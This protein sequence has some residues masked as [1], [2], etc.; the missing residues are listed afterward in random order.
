MPQIAGNGGKYLIFFWGFS[1]IP[2]SIGGD[3]TNTRCLNFI[4]KTLQDLIPKFLTKIAFVNVTKMISKCLRLPE[5][6][7]NF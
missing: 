3:A 6:V 1:P 2:P 7:V 4:S 5:M